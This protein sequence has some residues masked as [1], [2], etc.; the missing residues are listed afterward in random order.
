MSNQEA[1]D[2]QA[3]IAAA[4]AQGADLNETEAGGGDYT[5]PAAGN[6]MA[7]FIGYIELGEQMHKGYQGSPDK[8]KPTA[9]FI[10]E[11]SGKNYPPKEFEGVKDGIRI[12]FK[13]PISRNEKSGYIKLFNQLNF[14]R[15]PQIKVFP[16]MLGNPFLCRVVHDTWKNAQ[17][18]DVVTAKL[19]DDNGFTFTAPAFTDPSDGETKTL[20]V[21]GA[22]SAQ[23]L[24]LWDFCSLPMW[25]SIYI[26]GEYPARKD[27]AGKETAPAKSKNVFQ[28]TIRAAHNFP[29][30]PIAEL[31][32]GDIDV[33]GAEAQPA[34]SEADS[35]ATLDA[36]AGAGPDTNDEIPF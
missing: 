19:R 34:R 25:N 16:Q 23:R 5:P 4:A 26:D 15:D 33:G 14:L 11:L 24:F 29:G 13:L 21:P 6:A 12:S 31:L 3:A 35:Q 20:N 18:K 9:M 27:A 30:S 28:N 22:I 10:F 8:Y 36:K 1:F 17:G 2:I 32:L 7:R